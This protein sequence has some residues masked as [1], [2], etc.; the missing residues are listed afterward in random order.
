MSYLFVY[1]SNYYLKHI[2][3]ELYLRYYYKFPTRRTKCPRGFICLIHR[4]RRRRMS[5]QGRLLAK[6][7]LSAIDIVDDSDD[8]GDDDLPPMMPMS[9]QISDTA[10]SS[11]KWK[12]LQKKNINIDVWN[13][14]NRQSC[15]T[16]HANTR[17]FERERFQLRNHSPIPTQISFGSA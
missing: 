5:A 10:T 4:D 17:L 7:A 13:W 15:R 16:A 14:L 9:H 12:K 2:C 11:K 8:D 1:L 6:A 3:C